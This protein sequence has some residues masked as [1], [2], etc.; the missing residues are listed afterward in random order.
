[1]EHAE[2][3]IASLHGDTRPGPAYR[4]L[5]Q[6]VEVEAALLGAILTN[7]R[8]FERVSEFLKAD[9]FFEPVHG[10]IFE[11]AAKMIERGQVASPLTLKHFF[12]NDE[13][14]AEIGGTAYLYELAASVVSVVNAA[15][16]GR[17]V[18]DLYIKRELI[19]LGEN[20]VNDAYA[21]DIE[22]SASQ[23]I[24]K[25]EQSLYDL[26]TSGETE[27]GSVSL[28]DAANVALQLAEEA[29]RRDSHIVGITTGLDLLDRKLGGLHSS[30]LL[31]LAGR[32]S[33]GK[34]ALATNIAFNAARAFRQEKDANGEMQ[35]VD[36]AIVGPR[37]LCRTSGRRRRKTC[38]STGLIWSRR[39]A[40]R[41]SNERR[42]SVAPGKS[43]VRCRTNWSNRAALP[44]ASFSAR[45]W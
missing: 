26:A 8:A 19:G 18:Q 28:K 12:E 21:N 35:T 33:M 31:I 1:M 13:A 44:A 24:E 15:D 9:H 42:L 3:N 7:N 30:D 27:R 16:Y 20:V 4:S 43:W 40:I 11:A 38:S 34:T 14:L 22:I 25:T 39:S 23:Q 32:P 37:W 6:N 29:F 2:N 41:N 5:P 36:G 10:R 45:A 17:T